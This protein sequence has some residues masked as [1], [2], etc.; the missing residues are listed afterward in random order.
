MRTAN[1]FHIEIL[2]CILIA[3]CFSSTLDGVFTMQLLFLRRKCS[4][5]KIFT[6]I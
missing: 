4:Y 6:G 2:I 1:L 3:S 5:F